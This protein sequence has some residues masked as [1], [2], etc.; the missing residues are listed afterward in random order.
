VRL[1]TTNYIRVD[2]LQGQVRQGRANHVL[3]MENSGVFQAIFK[4]HEQSV[5]DKLCLK[6]RASVD[7]AVKESLEAQI[8]KEVLVEFLCEEILCII[9]SEVIHYVFELFWRILVQSHSERA[10]E[11]HPII[12][13]GLNHMTEYL[14]IFF[15]KSTILELCISNSFS[16]N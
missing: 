7:R 5:L 16:S 3:V 11:K 14:S 15:S 13:K 10:M 9:H 4:F 2:R 1:I 6:E 8:P 12:H